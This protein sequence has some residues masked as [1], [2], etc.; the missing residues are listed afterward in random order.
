MFLLPKGNPLAEQVSTAGLD[1]AETLE[2]LR[3]GKLNGYALFRF[4]SAE[5]ILLYDEGKLASASVFQDDIRTTDRAALHLLIDLI[6]LA[7]G[8]NFSVYG[9]PRTVTLALLA[10]LGGEP[11]IYQQEVRNT[12]LN[13]LLARIKTKQMTATLRVASG[14]RIG[15]IFYHTGTTVGFYNDTSTGIETS[16]GEVQRIAGLPDAC[17]DLYV[18]Q[19]NTPLFDLA[20]LADIRNLWKMATSNPFELR[21]FDDTAAT[22]AEPSIHPIVASTGA[23]AAVR[24]A[25]VLDAAQRH[26]G[27]LGKA[28]AEKELATIGG[29]A[30]L[31]QPDVVQQLLAALEKGAKLLTSSQNIRA[32]KE[33]INTQLQQ[34]HT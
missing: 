18:L 24:E 2:K 11:L 30:A 21:A 9:L 16:A 33:A 13:A 8:G 3:Q 34:L 6:L 25:V 20:G 15:L 31:Q 19:S 28:L 27:I 5:T 29:G 4:P 17:I 10:L 22:S 1:L 7:S 12:D 26:I 14:S 32:M 23:D